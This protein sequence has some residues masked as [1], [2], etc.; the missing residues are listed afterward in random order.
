MFDDDFANRRELRAE[1]DALVREIC[2]SNRILVIALN[3]KLRAHYHPK[4]PRC[5]CDTAMLRSIL[6]GLQVER[7]SVAA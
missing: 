7:L 5:A 4:T 6:V 1:I 2:G 3:A